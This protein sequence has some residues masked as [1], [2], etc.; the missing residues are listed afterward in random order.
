MVTGYDT[1]D[2]KYGTIATG[3]PGWSLEEGESTLGKDYNEKLMQTG[4]YFGTNHPSEVM[5]AITEFGYNVGAQGVQDKFPGFSAAIQEGNYELAA[6]N[7]IWK[8]PSATG[9]IMEDGQEVFDPKLTSKWYD[10]VGHTRATSIYDSI[11][12]GSKSVQDADLTDKIFDQV[13]HIDE[14][15]LDANKIIGTNL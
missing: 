5:H 9:T 4:H 13:R 8:D 14:T 1:T 2:S 3:S 15:N 11:I 7:L 6:E 10:Q 12:E